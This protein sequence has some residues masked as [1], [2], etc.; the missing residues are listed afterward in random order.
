MG[1]NGFAVRLMAKMGWKEGMGLGV[2]GEGI[3]TAL[4]IKKKE[5][6][7]GLGAIKKSEWGDNWWERAFEDAVKKNAEMQKDDLVSSGSSSSES[8]DDNT[9]SEKLLVAC[10]GRRCRAFGKNKLMRVAKQESQLVVPANQQ[11]AELKNDV[12]SKKL[13]KQKKKS[14]K[15]KARKAKEATKV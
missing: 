15:K 14:S 2:A 13:K 11:K 5:D 9:H 8:E 3:K 1:E 6:K 10:G 4:K 12:I 7:L